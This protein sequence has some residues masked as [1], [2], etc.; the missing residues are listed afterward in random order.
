MKKLNRTKAITRI[1]GGTLACTTMIMANSLSAFAYTLETGTYIFTEPFF[2]SSGVKKAIIAE[3]MT[4]TAVTATAESLSG[5]NFINFFRPFVI[6][7]ADTII[8]VIP[9][10]I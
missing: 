9:I 10:I 7:G 3:T 2:T 1:I 5:L 6:A 4:V 8:A